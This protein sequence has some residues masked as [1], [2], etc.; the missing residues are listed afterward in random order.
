MTTAVQGG[1]GTDVAD[2]RVEVN[3]PAI[4]GAKTILTPSAVEFVA[5]LERRFGSRRRALLDRRRE[6]QAHLDAG[7]KPDFLPETTEIRR[8]SWMAAPIPAD[9]QD[10]R[11]EITGP[12]D[13]KMVINALNSGANVFMADFED[14]CAPTWKNLIEGQQNL[15]D[16]IERTI[17]FVVPRGQDLPV[18]RARRD[19]HG[20]APRMAPRGEAPAR[21][22]AARL[23][24]PLRL[25]P[26]LL[27]QRAPAARARNGP[28]LLSSET[29]EPSRGTAVERRLPRGAGGA[30][31]CRPARSARPS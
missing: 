25:R 27:P 20:P 3:G 4:S 21:R 26:L 29:G 7:W 6:V 17:E 2:Q 11:V 31:S 24:Q 14:S 12:V 5:L 22:R 23:G 9:L 19:A 1:R 13:R 15:I 28:V 8:G 16:A 10:R 30:R 18:E